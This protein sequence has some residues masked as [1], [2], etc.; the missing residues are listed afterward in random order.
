MAEISEPR[1][2]G[3]DR[4]LAAAAIEKRRAG[5]R[6]S[7]EEAAALR[8]VER[9]R[10]DAARDEHYRVCPKRVY[11][12]MAGRQQKVLDGQAAIHG[13]P[14]ASAT[15]DLNAVVRWLHDFLAKH[16]QRLSAISDDPLVEGASQELKDEYVR[17]QIAEKREKAALAR[18]DRMEREKLLI[19]RHD[20]RDFLG[21]IAGILRRDLA[22]LQRDWPEAY[23]VMVESLGDVQAHIER[24][25]TDDP[26]EPTSEHD[27]APDAAP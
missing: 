13:I 5:K 3:E 24:T 7:R 15:I 8:R 17:T 14:I 11:A 12:A 26:S 23:R 10:D 16:A 4:R 21:T 2:G 27:G 22:T 18:L 20:V 25:F 9:A 6:P 19:A 1:I